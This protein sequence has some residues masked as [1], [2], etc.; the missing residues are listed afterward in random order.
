MNF[1]KKGKIHKITFLCSNFQYGFVFGIT[2]LAALL[3]APVFGEYGS[4][5][6]AKCTYNFGALVQSLCALSFGCLAYVDNLSI[7][8]G[9]SY[10][11]R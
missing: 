10:F 11:L 7:F 5:L 2:N 3:T 1:L 6:G 8:L 9:L 4:R